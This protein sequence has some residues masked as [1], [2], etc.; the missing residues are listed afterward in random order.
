MLS[1]RELNSE[2][3][4]NRTWINERLTFTHGYGL[5]L[6]P[7][8]EVT[9]EGLPVLFIKNLPPESTVDLQGRR[10]EHLLRRALERPR[11]RARRTRKEFHY[12]TGDDNVYADT[13]ARAACRVGGSLR[14]LLFAIR[15]GS[16]KVAALATTSP[17]T[18]A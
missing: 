15:F 11:V 9:P 18:A 2:S 4:P 12:P 1:A 8:N 10:A 16:G 5:T 7:V 6:G 3:L 17:P 14:K 13:R